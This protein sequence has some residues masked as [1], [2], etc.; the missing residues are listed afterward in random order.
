MNQFPIYYEI[1]A[2]VA[3][4][5]NRDLLEIKTVRSKEV[6]PDYGN[7]IAFTISVD[8]SII[9]KIIYKSKNGKTDRYIKTINSFEN[10]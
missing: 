9:K 10:L 2:C 7:I 6:H 8:D 1:E 5:I 4:P 3:E